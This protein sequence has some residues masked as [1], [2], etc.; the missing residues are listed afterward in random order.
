MCRIKG[1]EFMQ[2][3]RHSR[4]AVAL[5]ATLGLQFNP[6]LGQDAMGL[7]VTAAP[8]QTTPTTLTLSE[9]D[10]LTQVEFTTSTI[11][12]DGLPVFSGVPLKALLDSLD[13]EGRVVELIALN[14][15]AVTIPVD[16]LEDSAPIVAT[17]QDGEVMSV[18]DKG[19]YWVVYPYD[20][21]PKYRTEV[22]HARS[23]WQ[24]NRIK[25]VD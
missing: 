3:C 14:D 10:A 7:Q 12:T 21:D 15:Y 1:S 9:L 11:W 13:A 23:I 19:P 17:R 8:S 20:S 24:L 18:R 5:V 6:A 16:E 25:L 22:V 2:A 4:I